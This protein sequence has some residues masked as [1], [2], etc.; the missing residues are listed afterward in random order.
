MLNLSFTDTQQVLVTV[1]GGVDKKGN[2]APLD[3]APVFASSDDTIIEVRPDPAGDPNSAL[4]V[5]VGPLASAAIVS[6][7]ADA[8]LG[9]EVSEIVDNI[10]IEITNSEATGF[11]MT[12]GAPSEQ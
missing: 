9:P 4:L 11:S 3:G 7:T 6:V 2:P 12:A 8:K 1:G 10:S 5:A